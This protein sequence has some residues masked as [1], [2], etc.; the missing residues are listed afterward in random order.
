MPYKFFKVPRNMKKKLSIA[1]CKL[2]EIPIKNDLRGNL[3]FIESNNHIPFN[4]KRVYY[5]YDVPRNESRAG[6]AHKVLNQFLIC[7]N[8]EVEILIDDGINERIIILNKPYEGL[9]LLPGIWREIRFIKENSI[10]LCL[11][12]QVYEESDYF[13]NYND[14]KN[15]VIQNK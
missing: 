2:I 12:D 6:H 15:S 3:S 9:L 5:L 10:C 14:F 4:I 13:R 1:D 11:A 8:G 7:L